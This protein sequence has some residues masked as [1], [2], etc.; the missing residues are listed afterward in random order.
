MLLLVPVVEV[1]LA[2]LVVVCTIG[3]KAKTNVGGPS[4]LAQKLNLTS[5]FN[6]ASA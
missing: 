4:G 5:S 3:T 6:E 2:K 1:V